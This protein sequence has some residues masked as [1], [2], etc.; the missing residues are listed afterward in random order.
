MHSCGGTALVTIP[1]QPGPWFHP[2][3][4]M[5]ERGHRFAAPRVVV[6][7]A[8]PFRF[9][10]LDGGVETSFGETVQTFFLHRCSNNQGCMSG[11]ET[12]GI[13]TKENQG[14]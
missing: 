5:A 6:V 3:H 8:S 13:S 12:V 2:Q 14:Y 10:R 4:L 11:G 7:V 9:I 1:R